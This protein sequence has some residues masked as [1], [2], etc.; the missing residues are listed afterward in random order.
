TRPRIPR[1]EL[2]RSSSHPAQLEHVRLPPERFKVAEKGP[3]FAG[4]LSRVGGSGARAGWRW[5]AAPATG[6][7]HHVEGTVQVDF[8]LAAVGLRHR[9]L[10]PVAEVV[11][12]DVAGRAS[13]DRFYRG[14]LRFLRRFAGDR[15]LVVLVRGGARG[16]HVP[17]GG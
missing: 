9:H 7:A 5:P 8:D 12:R 3:A 1:G 6:T 13:A 4:P 2:R 16:G 15:L 14:R 17:Q 11:R 10:V